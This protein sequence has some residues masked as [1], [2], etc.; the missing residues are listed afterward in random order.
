MSTYRD[1]VEYILEQNTIMARAKGHD[2]PVERDLD[3]LIDNAYL[4]LLDSNITHDGI[5]EELMLHIEMYQDQVIAIY[6]LYVE[7]E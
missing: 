7:D 6:D 5:E 2:H 4:N 3:E 1:K